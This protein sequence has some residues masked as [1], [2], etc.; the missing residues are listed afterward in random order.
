MKKGD[1]HGSIKLQ[2]G[3]L[4]AGLVDAT[5]S[6][7]NFFAAWGGKHIDPPPPLV[8]H[9]WPFGSAGN[10]LAGDCWVVMR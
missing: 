10:I 3:S 8:I 5:T 4:I 6:F 2:Q 7:I 9:E 1:T